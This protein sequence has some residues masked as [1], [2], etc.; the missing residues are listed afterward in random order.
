MIAAKTEILDGS[1]AGI[2]S[3]AAFLRAGNIVSFPTETVYGLGADATNDA[4]VAAIF[5]TKSRP[6]F[7]PLI[8]H[9][10]DLAA[11]Q[12]LASFNDVALQLADRFWPGPL[13][14]VLPLLPE[15]G[16][17][18]LVTAGL[19]TVAVRLPADKS[20]KALLTAFGGPVAAPS[21]NPSGRISPT[22]AEHVIKA[23]DGKIAAVLDGGSCTVGLESTIVAAGPPTLLLRPGGTPE[24]DISRLVPLQVH[25]GDA[26][27]SPG[28][29]A[30]HY[31]P[32]APLR[33]NVCVKQGNEVHLGFGSIE[34]DLTLSASGDLREAAMNLF[35]HL[36]RLDGDGRQIAVAPIPEIGLGLAINDRLRRAAAPR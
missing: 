28:Q 23:L 36:H 18:S 24:E 17:S 26:I 19:E 30:S 4:A 15:H 33:M 8:V 34:G 31:A 9:V 11:A 3:A 6:R 35:G 20:A 29:L 22:T 12:E 10:R 32:N 5:E 2:A 13:S 21:A 16:L 27:T 1:A 25:E 7:N 14:L